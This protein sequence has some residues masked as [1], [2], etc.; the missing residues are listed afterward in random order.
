MLTST[1]SPPIIST[2][3]PRTGSDFNVYDEICKDFIFQPTLP[4]RG[5]TAGAG[6]L[7][8]AVQTFQPTLPARG[9]TGFPVDW[10][11]IGKYFNPRS[12]HGERQ[13]LGRYS[14][15]SRQFQPT[16]PA[17]GATQQA[18]Q[19]EKTIFI[20]THAPRTGSDSVCRVAKSANGISTHA[21]R[22]GSDG[23]GADAG[24]VSVDFNPRSPHGE[25]PYAYIHHITDLHISTHA[26]RTGSDQMLYL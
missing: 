11:A 10:I 8:G 12:P 18:Y 20:S 22:T 24:A 7:L 6:A 9:A 13:G 2:H 21:P 19:Y 5:A 16:L 4:A 26:P 1:V 14:E 15:Q 23:A 17:R 25:R 3:A